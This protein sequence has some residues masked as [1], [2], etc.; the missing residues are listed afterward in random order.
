MFADL[1]SPLNELL[2]TQCGL[3]PL[4]QLSLAMLALKRTR[5]AGYAERDEV[6][7]V[8]LG[9]G[10]NGMRIGCGSITEQLATKSVS[11]QTKALSQTGLKLGRRHSKEA[12]PI[13][14]QV[15]IYHFTVAQPW[16]CYRVVVSC[17]MRSYKY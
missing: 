7:S 15:E 10:W 5:L 1:T 9:M 13:T 3:H 16:R 17:Q 4:Q 11:P 14:E 2:W 8:R 12:A 6:V